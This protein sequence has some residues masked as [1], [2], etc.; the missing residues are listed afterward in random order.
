MK[1]KVPAYPQIGGHTFSVLFDRTLED[2]NIYGSTN[3]RTQE[4]RINPLRPI[5]QQVGSLIHEFYHIVA[6]VYANNAISEEVIDSTGEGFLQIF[7]QFG[8]ELDWSDIPQ[9]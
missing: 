9:V 2:T 5:S 4:I 1:I 6:V 3:F 7:N 8:I